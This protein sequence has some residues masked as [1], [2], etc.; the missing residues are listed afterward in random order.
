MHYID[1]VTQPVKEETK[2]V[3]VVD[4]LLVIT[5]QRVWADGATLG[6]EFMC[7]PNVGRWLA[8]QLDVAADGQVSEIAYDEPPDHLVVFLRGGEHGAPIN[9]HVHNDRE[10][11]ASH[12]RTYTLS[13]MSPAVARK[14]AEDIRAC[15]AAVRH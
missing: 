8:D 1:S 11:S 5:R 7:D 3:G 10:E 2:V 13:A 14:L 6:G 4:G 12:G 15:L 9:V